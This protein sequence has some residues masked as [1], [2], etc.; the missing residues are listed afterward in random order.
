MTSTRLRFTKM[1]GAGNDF[2]VLDG[3]SQDLSKITKAQWQLMANRQ[4]GVGA[5]QI[6][7]VEKSTVAEAEFRYRIFNS[8]GGEVEQCGNGSR[9]FVRFVREKGLTKN[10]T[11]KVQVAH[12]I[13]SLT[14][15]DD[16]QITVDMGAPILSTEQIPF[17]AANLNS[18]TEGGTTLYELKLF[19]GSVWINPI[20]MGNPHAVQ[21]VKDVDTAA[22]TSEGPEIEAHTAFPKKVNAG[23]MQIQNRHEIKLRVF[24]RGSGET[25]ACGTG[26][27][28]AVVSGILR[29]ELDS[30]VVVQTR[31][32]DLRIAWDFKSSAESHVMMTGPAQTVFEGE[33]TLE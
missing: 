25:L 30:P 19:G 11:V 5:D 4:L 17:N 28:A 26:A 6:L 7:L 8:D 14:E 31:G 12:T 15:N 16:G 10:R 21:I 32:G 24:E 9:C 33:I 22:V 20:S 27:C 2:I 3:I 13:L 18:K 29:G 23:F 1:H